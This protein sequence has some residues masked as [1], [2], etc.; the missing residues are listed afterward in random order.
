MEIILIVIMIL[1]SIALCVWLGYIALEEQRNQKSLE[2]QRQE[3]CQRQWSTDPNILYK[4]LVEYYR[5]AS[6][7]EQFALYLKYYHTLYFSS[8]KFV[9]QAIDNNLICKVITQH[10]IRDKYDF[11]IQQEIS[12]YELSQQGKKYVKSY[13]FTC[14]NLPDYP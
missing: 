11:I 7:S 10:E 3:T 13:P 5:N 14:S 9:T 12:H 6:Q 8:L 2:K 4:Q 1:L